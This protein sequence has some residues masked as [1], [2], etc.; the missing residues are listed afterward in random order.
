MTHMYVAFSFCCVFVMRVIVSR[1]ITVSVQFAAKIADGNI[2]TVYSCS[3][4]KEPIKS[5]FFNL[6]GPEKF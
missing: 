6:F 5:W 4:N 2:S 3:F 1:L